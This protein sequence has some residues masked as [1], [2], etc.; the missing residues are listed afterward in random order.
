MFR[1]VL[2]TC[3]GVAMGGALGIG[4]AS[5]AHTGKEFYQY[6]IKYVDNKK[7]KGQG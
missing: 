6:V 5:W 2:N 3:S 4:I 7:G 1:A